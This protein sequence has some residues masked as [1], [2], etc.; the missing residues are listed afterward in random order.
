[1]LDSLCL[2]ALRI[3]YIGSTINYNN[4]CHY[5]INKTS[6]IVRVP[7][8]FL[9]IV[10]ILLSRELIVPLFSLFLY[11]YAKKEKS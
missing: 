1:M 8:I 5:Y 9:V 4:I 7:E 3:F 11:F 6:S 2:F 10:I